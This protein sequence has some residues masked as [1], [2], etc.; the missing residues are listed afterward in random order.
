MAGDWELCTDKIRYYHDAGSMIPFHKNLTARG[1][2]ALIFRYNQLYYVFNS[3]PSL[4][5]RYIRTT[6][7]LV[8]KI[9]KL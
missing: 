5:F 7:C 2:R 4:I 6:F 3:I 8:D 9:G 1:Y